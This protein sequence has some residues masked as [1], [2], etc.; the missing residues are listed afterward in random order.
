MTSR[1]YPGAELELFSRARNWKTYYK[2]LIVE[3]LG[4]EVLEVGAGIGATTQVLCSGQEE[5]WVCLEPDPSMARRLA[6][7]IGNTELPPCCAVREGVVAELEEGEVF[8]SIIYIDVLEHIKDDR[9]ELEQ[10]CSHLKSGGFLTVLSPA[11]QWLYTPFDKAIGHCRR[12]SK[13]TLLRVAPRELECVQLKY[14]DSVGAFASLG[15]KMVL[16]QDTPTTGQVAFWDTVL[17]PLSSA[18][19]PISGYRLGK[20]VLATWRRR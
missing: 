10:A 11:H 1:A 4:R 5:R 15:N 7:R 16:R 13:G 2:R 9:L 17:I 6:T 18:L 3:Y 20:S 14:L 19:D 12:Y 8:D